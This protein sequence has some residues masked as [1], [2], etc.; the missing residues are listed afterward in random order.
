MCEPSKTSTGLKRRSK[1]EKSS[2]SPSTSNPVRA[3]ESHKES[4]ADNILASLSDVSLMSVL[5][6]LATILVL[7]CAILAYSG[8][9]GR[10]TCVGIDLGTTFSV[11]AVRS[12]GGIGDVEVVDGRDGIVPSV[13]WYGGGGEVKVGKE[14]KEE[15]MKDSKNVVYNAKRYI[16]RDDVERDEWREFTL[17]PTPLD[18]KPKGFDLISSWS[19]LT[20]SGSTHTPEE[21]GSTIISHLLNITSLHLGHNQIKTAVISVPTKFNQKQRQ[22]TALA[23]KLAGIKVTRILEEPEAAALA[24]GLVKKPGVNFILVYDFGG[25]TLDVSVL[26]V[27]DGYVEVMASEG[28]EFLGG[29]DFDRVIAEMFWKELEAKGQIVSNSNE[30]PHGDST[31]CT[32]DDLYVISEGLKIEMSNIYD[33][34]SPVAKSSCVTYDSKCSP[35]TVEL[36]ITKR[37][38]DAI[39]E[40]LFSRSAAPI[41]DV[42]EKLELQPEDI[43]EVVMVGGTS[44]MPKIRELVKE[45][46]KKEKLNVE[47]DPDVTVAFGCAEVI[48]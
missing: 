7:S 25:G 38:Y 39:T 16:G 40:D 17:T 2:S 28:D 43:D 10:T 1:R 31:R 11:V 15:I 47:I 30:C 18:K 44:R 41:H 19:F 8:F 4:L 33:T 26:H 36:S 29:G 42:L 45:V 34:P 21:V 35:K 22:A 3:D 5:P 37:K 9:R 14:A 20:S 27:S 13:V 6:I 24:Y 23:F 32:L 12:N 48:D 46:L